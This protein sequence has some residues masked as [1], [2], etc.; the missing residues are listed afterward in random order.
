LDM[1]FDPFPGVPVARKKKHNN[2]G[3]LKKN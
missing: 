1:D 2:A 3:S